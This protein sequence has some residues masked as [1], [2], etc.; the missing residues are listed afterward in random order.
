MRVPALVLAALA[1][2]AC[3]AEVKEV[4]PRV[5]NP[6]GAAAPATPATPA[7]PAAQYKRIT[8]SKDYPVMTCVVSG[9]PLKSM[10]D[11]IAIEYQGREVQFCCEECVDEFLANPGPAL[12]KIDAAKKK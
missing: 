12:A 7:A 9:E 1:V 3:K 5:E 8:P 11:P 4:T 10:G 2:A 6:P